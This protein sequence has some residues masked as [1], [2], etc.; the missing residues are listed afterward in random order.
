[1]TDF[2]ERQAA[3]AH[4][5]FVLGAIKF[6]EFKLKLHETNPE[7]PLSP[8]YLNLRTPDNKGGP[9]TPDVLRLIGTEFAYRIHTSGMVFDH[10]AGVPRAGEPFADALVAV[11]MQR[12]P[13]IL[14]MSK[15]TDGDHRT[16]DDIYQG[17]YSPGDT[18]LIVDDL[19]TRAGSKVETVRTLVN[20]GLKAS[21]CIVL[22][23]RCQGGGQELF[24]QTGVQLHAIFRLTDLLEFY[25]SDRRISAEE[26]DTVLSYL[27]A[28]QP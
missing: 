12:R 15:R 25:V 16:V 24:D 13:G 7:A 19:I 10:V 3:I 6:G 20:H 26:R 4:Y 27:A 22:V 21:D 18:V 1:M 5:L 9:L 28:T 17:G 14:R 23:D 2:T 11:L 8:I